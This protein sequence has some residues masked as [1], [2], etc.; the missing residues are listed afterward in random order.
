MG[1]VGLRCQIVRKRSDNVSNRAESSN[2]VQKEK[3]IMRHHPAHAADLPISNEIH[4]LLLKAIGERHFKVETWEIGE[5]AIREWLIRNSPDAFDQPVTMGYQWKSLFL[6]HGTLLRTMYSGTS[7]HCLVE[8]DRIEYKGTS[9]SPNGFANIVGGM[10]RN[11]WKV[12]WVM[13][14]DC[15]EWKLAADLRPRTR[16]CDAS[17]GG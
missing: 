9:I 6:P 5:M 16:Q 10:R 2:N 15:K 3:I 1:I 14:P 17:F 7:Y 11:A 8:K 12:I 13:L 4:H